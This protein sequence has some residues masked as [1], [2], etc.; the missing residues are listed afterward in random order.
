MQFGD[1]VESVRHS[2]HATLSRVTDQ[3]DGARI[4]VEAK[5]VFVLVEKLKSEVDVIKVRSCCCGMH[6][7]S[8]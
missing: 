3:Q 2:S 1:G 5:L 6:L 7:S 8:F 4:A